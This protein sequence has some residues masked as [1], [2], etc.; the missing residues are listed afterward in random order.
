VVPEVRLE[1]LDER[2]LDAVNDLVADPA[3]LRFTRIEE[4]PPEGFAGSWIAE[5]G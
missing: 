1:R 2:W 4:P 3:V 5:A